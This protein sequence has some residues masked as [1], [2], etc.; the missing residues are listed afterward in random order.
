M[1][2]GW[3][4]YDVY[5]NYRHVLCNAHLLRDLQGII[6]STEQ[7]W[8]QQMQEFLKQ[9]L[10]LKKQYKGIL[11]KM[12]QQSLFTVYQSILKEQLI[13]SMELKKEKSGPLLKIYGI[14]LSDTKLYKYHEKTKTTCLTSNRTGYKNRNGSLESHD[15]IRAF[16]YLI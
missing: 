3:K 13:F 2:D 16:L 10:T 11:P 1:H 15:F 6:D 8:A 12:E 4:P 5:T 7:K 14:A 9:A